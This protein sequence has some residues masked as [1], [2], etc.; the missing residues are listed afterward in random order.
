MADNKYLATLRKLYKDLIDQ[1]QHVE[2]MDDAEF[3][4]GPSAPM[5]PESPAHN[6]RRILATLESEYAA[7]RAIH[8]ELAEEFEIRAEL[9]DATTRAAQHQ[10]TI[11]RLNGELQ[12]LDHLP[13]IPAPP[14]EPSPAAH[15][16]AAQRLAEAVARLAAPDLTPRESLTLPATVER[17]RTQEGRAFLALC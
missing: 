4:I 3:R 9:H 12:R 17:L 11:D 5:H 15:Q 2:A 14:A 16:Q 7:H 1:R 8:P 6:I 10:R 13:P